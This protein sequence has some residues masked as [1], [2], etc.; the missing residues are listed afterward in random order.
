MDGEGFGLGG[1]EM[2]GGLGCV[3]DFFVGG[4]EGL[5]DGHGCLRCVGY[6]EGGA[7]VYVYVYIWTI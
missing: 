7:A 5:L 1:G 4:G 6:E 2:G 3:L